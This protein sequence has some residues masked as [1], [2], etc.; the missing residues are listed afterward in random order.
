MGRVAAAVDG[1]RTVA[2]EPAI[3]GRPLVRAMRLRALRRV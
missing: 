2:R 1:D 3:E